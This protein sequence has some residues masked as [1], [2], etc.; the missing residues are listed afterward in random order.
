MV[1]NDTGMLLFGIAMLG[2]VGFLLWRSVSPSTKLT[3]FLRDSEGRIVQ[4]LER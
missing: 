2:L 3:E 1:N 4:I